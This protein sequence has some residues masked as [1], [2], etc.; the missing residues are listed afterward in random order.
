V[1]QIEQLR[2]VRLGTPDLD[3][4]C[5]FASRVLGLQ[6]VGRDDEQAWF[7]SDSR[8]HT[9][10]YFRGDPADQTLGIE[11]RDADALARAEQELAAAGLAVTRGDAGASAARRVQDH[12][13]VTPDGGPRVD[14]VLRPL[15]SGWRYFPSR[16]AGITGFHGVALRAAR[17]RA[18]LAFWTGLLSGRVSDYVGNSAYVRTDTAH[19]R[20][21]LYESAGS[22]ILEIQFA[23]EGVDQLM[24]NSYWLQGA[25]VPVVHGPGRRPASQQMFMSLRGPDGM[26]F[27]L[28]TPGD[29][30]AAH[31]WLPRQFRH[32][33]DSLC[34][35]GSRSDVPEWQAAN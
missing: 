30:I 7:R 26:L 13:S 18:A 29:E 3:G 23:V 32:A 19:H 16:D 8:D 17:P 2:Y 11:L 22:G 6:P 4:A 20:L 14:L 33:A 24:Q 9:L 25:Q 34:A 15:H 28:V 5:D 12:L 1:I 10:C 21:T 27:G 31:D 35:W